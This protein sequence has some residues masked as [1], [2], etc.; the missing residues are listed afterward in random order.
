MERTI[1]IINTFTNLIKLEHHHNFLE[2]CHAASVVPFGLR[3]K[4]APS[5]MGA[6]SAE[7]SESWN[8]IL[9]QAQA[10]LVAKKKSTKLDGRNIQVLIVRKS[11]LYVEYFPAKRAWV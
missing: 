3:I 10:S 9:H 4:K 5:M 6:P 11:L 7:F 2:F 1:L 8:G